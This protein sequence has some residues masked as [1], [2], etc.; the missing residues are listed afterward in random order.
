[1]LQTQIFVDIVLA[2]CSEHGT[3]VFA[4]FQRLIRD[5]HPGSSCGASSGIR[6][7]S[8]FDKDSEQDWADR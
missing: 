7:L 5:P 4:D 6:R 3:Q 8:E 1:M 2:S